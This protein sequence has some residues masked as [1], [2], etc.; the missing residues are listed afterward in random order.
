M[1]TTKEH[2]MT[3]MA[4]THRYT[5]PEVADQFRVSERTVLNWLRSGRLKGYRLG[6]PKAGWRI[7]APDLETFAA[8]LRGEEPS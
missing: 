2:G 4:E 5:V 1:G 7:D 8:Q 6:G 3:T